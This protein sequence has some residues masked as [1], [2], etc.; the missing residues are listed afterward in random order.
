[1]VCSL[2][3]KT[4]QVEQQAV[5]SCVPYR[6]SRSKI[7]WGPK[8]VLVMKPEFELLL[9]IKYMQVNKSWRPGYFS[10]LLICSVMSGVQRS[11]FFYLLVTSHVNCNSSNIKLGLR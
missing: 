2:Q 8:Q 9:F 5:S 4:S 1:M 10:D 3:L 6:Q 11:N 7:E